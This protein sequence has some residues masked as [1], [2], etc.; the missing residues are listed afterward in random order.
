MKRLSVA[1]AKER[2]TYFMF[3]MKSTSIGP[4]F[5]SQQEAGL[6]LNRT[7]VGNKTGRFISCSTTGLAGAVPCPWRAFRG[8]FSKVAQANTRTGARASYIWLASPLKYALLGALLIPSSRSGDT[9][10]HQLHRSAIAQQGMQD[11]KLV[12]QHNTRSKEAM[13]TPVHTTVFC[14]NFKFAFYQ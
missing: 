1:Q 14:V 9:R 10:A 5:S 8:Q 2:R 3:L 6:A 4:L 13:H 7:E 12:W 11:M